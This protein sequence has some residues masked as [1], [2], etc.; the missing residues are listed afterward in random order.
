MTSVVAEVEDEI[1]T[2]KIGH[3]TILLV[4]G[5][6]SPHQLSGALLNLIREGVGPIV[7]RAIGAGAVNQAAKGCAIACTLGAQ[8]GF[9]VTYRLRFEGVT[10]KG[11]P[12]SAMAFEV[13]AAP[14]G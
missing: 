5:A 4:K 10:I 11:E 13:V 7:A 3:E 9:D 6:T 1:S 8:E 12:R 2:R 14:K